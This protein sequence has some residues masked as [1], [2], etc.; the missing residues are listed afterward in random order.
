[1]IRSRYRWNVCFIRNTT[2]SNPEK[3]GAEF[4][5]NVTGSYLVGEKRQT[6]KEQGR[7]K[8]NC[9][10]QVVQM[11]SSPRKGS[12]SVDYLPSRGII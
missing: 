5:I 3:M 4:W 9:F 7:L 10:D 11:P 8:G 1:V 6:W 12:V 2:G